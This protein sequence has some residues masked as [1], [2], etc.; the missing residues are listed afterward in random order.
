VSAQAEADRLAIRELIDRYADAI[1][2]ADWDQHAA[3]FAEDATWEVAAPFNF[4]VVGRANIREFVSD[5]SMPMDFLVQ[6]NGSTVVHGLSETR[7]SATTSVQEL[8]RGPNGCL[9]NFGIYYDTLEKR[10]GRWQFTRRKFQPLYFSPNKH[11]GAAPI[12]RA[13]LARIPDGG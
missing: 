12:S 5:M 2:R 3:V 9:T 4:H 13:D 11:A 1:T 7:A 6:P 8:G 10:A